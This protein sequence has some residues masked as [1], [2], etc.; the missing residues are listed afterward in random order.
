MKWILFLEMNLHLCIFISKAKRLN[1]I[2]SDYIRL[3]CFETYLLYLSL[4]PFICLVLELH[5]K[6]IPLNSISFF[7]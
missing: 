4:N 6:F 7:S 2:K 5:I 3:S 1:G